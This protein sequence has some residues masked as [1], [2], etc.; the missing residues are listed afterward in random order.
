VRSTQGAEGGSN[1]AIR[2]RRDTVE[3]EQP[4][5]MPVEGEIREVVRRDVVTNLGREPQNESELVPRHKG[6]DSLSTA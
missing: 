4:A 1:M 2:K 6:F 5:E 3:H